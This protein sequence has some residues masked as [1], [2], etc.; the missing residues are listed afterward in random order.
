MELYNFL[1]K[2]VDRRFRLNKLLPLKIYFDN[3]KPKKS[4]N[5][6]LSIE[7]YKFYYNNYLNK[8]NEFIDIYSSNLDSDFKINA[9]NNMNYSSTWVPER[10]IDQ[11][12]AIPKD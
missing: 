4:Y 2:L 12:I 10:S 3:D 1:L 8:K 11:I 5:D 9:I 6:T 7:D